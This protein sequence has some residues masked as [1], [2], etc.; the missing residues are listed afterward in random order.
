MITVI[1]DASPVEVMDVCADF[2][3]INPNQEITFEQYKNVLKFHKAGMQARNADSEAV[4]PYSV[5]K[6]TLADGY[7]EYHAWDLCHAS[8]ELIDNLTKINK[9]FKRYQE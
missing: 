3:R 5:E 4:N 2:F 6:A 9:T 1:H 7:I 8:T